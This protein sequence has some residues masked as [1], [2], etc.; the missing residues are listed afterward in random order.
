MLSARMLMLCSSV[1]WSSSTW[2]IRRRRELSFTW[3]ASQFYLESR[4]VPRS[5]ESH[6][7]ISVT[8]VYRTS[9]WDSSILLMHSC[10]SRELT[11][12]LIRFSIA[13]N[14]GMRVRTCGVG[15]Y[16][17]ISIVQFGV[18]ISCS[19]LF[20]RLTSSKA[21]CRRFLV[22]VMKICLHVPTIGIAT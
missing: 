12:H 20:N 17:P 10:K 19:K 13:H 3:W 6:N 8:L 22:Q 9:I 11:F 7:W 18:I 1:Q 14:G 15:L 2:S 21:N 16:M 5:R 4:S